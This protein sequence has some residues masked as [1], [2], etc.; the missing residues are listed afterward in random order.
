[1]PKASKATAAETVEVEGYEGH[2]ENFDGGYTVAFETYT[3]DTDLTP[4]FTGL[5]DD[6]CQAAHW[7]YVIRGKLTYKSAGGDE[8]FETGDAYYVPPGHTPVL[9]AGTEIVEFSPTKELHE[10]LAVVEKNMAA[11]S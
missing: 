9:Y 4:Y 8:T 7:G 5:P 6:Q 2:I 3:A 1:M 10:T 11:E